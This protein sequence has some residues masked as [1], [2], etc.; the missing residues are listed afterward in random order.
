M[1][2][3]D[4][5][6]VKNIPDDVPEDT[7]RERIRKQH[8]ELNLPPPKSKIIELETVIPTP[9]QKQIQSQ[10]LVEPASTSKNDNQFDVMSMIWVIVAVFIGVHIAL[11]WGARAL[12]R[13]HLRLRPTCKP[14]AWGYWQ[15]L[16]ALLGVVFVPYS[17]QK[18]GIST[19][20][21]RFFIFAYILV[22][23]PIAILT[24]RRNRAA[25]VILTVLMGPL[26]WGINWGY[27]KE[28]WRELAPR[29][30]APSVTDEHFAKALSEIE[31]GTQDKGL[32]A[33]CFAEANGD[34][35]K[36]KAAYLSKRSI[37]L[38][39]HV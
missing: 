34:E 11:I 10:T 19:S 5:T 8:P 27:L 25:M 30:R 9:S 37:D 28:R 6:L 33:R 31:N 36:A 14:F 1:Q 22:F 35:S 15:A 21:G 24:L 3:P 7:A 23:Y 12:N 13:R 29:P 16:V 38:A 20:T 32:W 26:Y 2:L 17:L 18:F 4:G 39:S